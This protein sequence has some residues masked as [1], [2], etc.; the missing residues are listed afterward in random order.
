M[1]VV[2]NTT[3]LIGLA[4]IQRFDLL[5]H[6]FGQVNIAQ[7]VYDEVMNTGGRK[8]IA[9]PKVSASAWIEVASVRDRT[10]VD[11]L[12]DE[13]DLGE[14]ETIVLARELKADWVIMDE[15]KGRQKLTHLGINKIRTLGILFK[16]KEMGLIPHVRP[17]LEKLQRNGFSV[18]QAVVDS[19]L[20]QSK[21]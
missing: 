20:K 18:N 7:A 3:P 14:A 19:I 5:Q 10:A 2:A 15:K 1:I 9:R 13:L 8:K 17:E 11:V 4:S 21:E 12:L 16:A 6:I